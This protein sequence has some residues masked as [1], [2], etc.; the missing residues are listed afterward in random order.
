MRAGRTPDF[1]ASNTEGSHEKRIHGSN[2]FPLTL[3]GV[4]TFVLSVGSVN[5]GA[6]Y[7]CLVLWENTVLR[8]TE[9]AEVSCKR[10]VAVAA[11]FGVIF[12]DVICRPKGYGE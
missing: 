1:T 11:P 3:G 9:R 7:Y 12:G 10:E 8:V 5:K 4:G 6:R 2:P